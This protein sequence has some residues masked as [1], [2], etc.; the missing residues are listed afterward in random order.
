MFQRNTCEKAQVSN[1][2]VLRK[3]N[4]NLRAEGPAI[5]LAQAN[6]LGIEAPVCREGCRPGRLRQSRQLHTSKFDKWP[7]R[8]PGTVPLHPSTQAD[9]LGWANGRAVGPDNVHQK[10]P[11]GDGSYIRSDTYFPHDAKR[12]ASYLTMATAM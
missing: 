1:L 8:W 10:P 7:G 4:A 12:V 3:S 6:G 2:V 11:S 5:C 9:G